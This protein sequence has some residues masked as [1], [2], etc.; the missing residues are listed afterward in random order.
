MGGGGHHV[1]GKLIRF[2]DFLSSS[3]SPMSLRGGG[4]VGA[5]SVERAGVGGRG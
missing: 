4:G 2:P 5:N 3:V 1:P